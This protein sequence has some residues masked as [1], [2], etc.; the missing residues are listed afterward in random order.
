MI[1]TVDSSKIDI[2]Q[3]KRLFRNDL[4]AIEQKVASYKK[5][6]N[7]T[8]YLKSNVYLNQINPMH[9]AMNVLEVVAETLNISVDDIK[10]RSRYRHIVVARQIFCFL[11]VKLSSVEMS[12]NAIGETIEKD[13]ATV[14]WGVKQATTLSQTDFTYK[15]KL[16]HCIDVFTKR[17][18][19]QD[20]YYIDYNHI[21]QY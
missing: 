2:S 1:Q 5:Q 8:Q 6:L 14:L 18:S 17:F 21:P 4:P 12:L 19:A 15:T 13:H 16:E 20:T 10:G 9:H 11:M 3:A 7:Q